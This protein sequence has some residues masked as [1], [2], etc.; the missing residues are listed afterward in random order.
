MRAGQPYP[1]SRVALTTLSSIGAVGQ[2]SCLNLG[3]AGGYAGVL[4]CVLLVLANVS[5]LE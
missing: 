2:H 4:A 1:I 5:G 3:F